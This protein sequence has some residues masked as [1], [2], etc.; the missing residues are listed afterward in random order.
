MSSPYIGEI[1][2]FGGNFAPV[3]WA[4][5]QGQLLS[6]QSSTA[7]FALVG[8]FYGG[9]GV[10]TFG[11]PDLRGRVP[12]HQGQGPGLSNYLIGQQG[13]TEAVT[14]TK[15]QIPSHSHPVRVN[16]SAATLTAPGGALLAS[17]G[18]VN[19]YDTSA[20]SAAMSGSAISNTG[21]SQP[22]DNMA[23][24]LVINYIISLFGVFPSQS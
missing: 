2:L 15:N 9:D 22:H 17:T 5:C 19:C 3:G 24:S 7:L 8:T 13:G 21:G 20:P 23:P 14:L 1:R 6:I 11:L 16:S 4:L 18:S 10:Q 12:I